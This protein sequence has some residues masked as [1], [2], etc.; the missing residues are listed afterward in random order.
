MAA[1]IEV[2]DESNKETLDALDLHA[3]L[4]NLLFLT[5]AR[6][7][8][9]SPIFR[10]SFILSLFQELVGQSVRFYFTPCLSPFP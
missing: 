8:Y 6:S 5:P 1:I 10:A 4:R 9:Y 7:Y 2:G 3:S